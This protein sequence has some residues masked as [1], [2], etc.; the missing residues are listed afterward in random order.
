MRHD[1]DRFTVPL[2]GLRRPCGMMAVQKVNENKVRSFYFSVKTG[3]L[4]LI[5]AAINSAKP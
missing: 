3:K 1:Y 4:R 5:D 2:C